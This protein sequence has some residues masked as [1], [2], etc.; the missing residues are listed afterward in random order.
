MLI[1][2]QKKLLFKIIDGHFREEKKV[3]IPKLLCIMVTTCGLSLN[4]SKKV[5][6]GWIKS[7]GRDVHLVKTSLMAMEFGN[8][9]GKRGLERKRRWVLES[10]QHDLYSHIFV[11]ASENKE[12][13]VRHGER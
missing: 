8:M 4:E 2:L 7:K 12:E 11:L 10:P 6:W 5:L 3:S 9:E 1:Q 13:E